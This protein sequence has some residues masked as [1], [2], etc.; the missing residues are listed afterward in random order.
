MISKKD[1]HVFGGKHRIL[2]Q[3]NEFICLLPHPD[4]REYISNY[5]K[6]TMQPLYK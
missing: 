5:N 4:L 2:L 3:A 6:T 1:I